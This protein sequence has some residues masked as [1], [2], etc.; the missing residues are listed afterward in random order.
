MHDRRC[1]ASIFVHW[2]IEDADKETVP[3]YLTTELYG[4][5]IGVYQKCEF[6]RLG[7]VDLRKYGG[8]Q[9]TC[10]RQSSTTLVDLNSYLVSS[11]Y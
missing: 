3:I 2:P 10:N 1:A 5:G 9:R 11:T 6:E 4:K 8:D 7:H